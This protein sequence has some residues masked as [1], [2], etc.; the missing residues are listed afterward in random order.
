MGIKSAIFADSLQGTKTIFEERKA[1]YSSGLS[2]DFLSA[3]RT[4][5]ATAPTRGN[6]IS[7]IMIMPQT[8]FEAKKVLNPSGIIIVSG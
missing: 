1:D 2:S 8:G 7:I 6:A 3:R 5:Q 4:T